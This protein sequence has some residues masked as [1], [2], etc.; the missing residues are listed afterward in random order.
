MGLERSTEKTKGLASA[1]GAIVAGLAFFGGPEV[2]SASETYPGILD[3]TYE[4]ACPRPLTR[5]LIC[6][7]TAAGG[8]E[9]A[10]RPFAVTLREYGLSEGKA[11]R[12]LAMALAALPD[13]RDSDGDGAADR[14]ELAV[15][16][17]PSGGELSDGPGFGCAP[18]L[19]P[20]PGAGLVCWLTSVTLG[21]LFLVARRPRSPR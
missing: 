5:C 18:Q 15:C 17:N 9:T 16:M 10:N 21:V 11:G 12:K 4:T 2:A 14:D 19:A 20:H 1:I 8:E 6:H 13:D 3:D 7:T